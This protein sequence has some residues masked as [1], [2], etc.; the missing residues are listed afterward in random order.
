MSEIHAILAK[1]GE[2][3][4]VKGIG[5]LTLDGIIVAST[6]GEEFLEDVVA[7]LSSFLISTTRR[8]LVEAGL[9]DNLTRFVLNSTHGKVVL[10][11][12][13][14]AFLVVITSQFA[15]LPSCLVEI[16]N[17][18]SNIRRVARMEV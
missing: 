12:V 10:L 8:A 7:G 11:N 5:L 16:Q 15:D 4:D 18:G 9:G 2:V 6:L 1:L 17:A 14:D 13:G 3:K